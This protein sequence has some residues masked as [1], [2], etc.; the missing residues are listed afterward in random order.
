[1]LKN[2]YLFLYIFSLSLLF[3]EKFEYLNGKEKIEYKKSEKKKSGKIKSNKTNK[4][5]EASKAI[6]SVL[7]NGTKK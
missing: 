2:K 4:G 1:M 6:I 5:L 7:K 3:S